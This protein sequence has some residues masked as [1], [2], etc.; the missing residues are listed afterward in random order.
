MNNNIV[1]DFNSFVQFTYGDVTSLN[2][3]TVSANNL[4]EVN[5]K[6][7]GT[8]NMFRPTSK[9]CGDRYLKGDSESTKIIHLEGNTAYDAP[10]P[11]NLNG[12]NKW[13]Y[14]YKFALPSTSK[15]IVNYR[16]SMLFG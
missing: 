4:G 11:F 9:L 14:L 3:G 7:D 1:I 16:I 10:D 5:T 15:G 12:L 8:K 6:S 2:A 13:T